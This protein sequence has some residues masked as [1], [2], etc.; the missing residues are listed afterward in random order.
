ML[1]DCSHF[2]IDK[3]FN[4]LQPKYLISPK[5]IELFIKQCIAENY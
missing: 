4:E 3:K 1:S 2:S 5:E